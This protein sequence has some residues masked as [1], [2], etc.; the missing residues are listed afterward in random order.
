MYKNIFVLYNL[1]EIILFQKVNR[2]INLDDKC[3]VSSRTTALSYVSSFS[4]PCYRLFYRVTVRLLYIAT[5]T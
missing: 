2:I 5:C 4:C 1:Y 3:A